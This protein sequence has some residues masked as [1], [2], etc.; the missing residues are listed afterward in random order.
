MRG[1]DRLSDRAIGQYGFINQGPAGFRGAYTDHAAYGLRVV[2]A[3][4]PGSVAYTNPGNGATLFGMPVRPGVD[5]ASDHAPNV[6]FGRTD[7]EGLYGV[8]DDSHF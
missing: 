2:P 7:V 1:N 6:S 4:T 5:P 3:G 8:D